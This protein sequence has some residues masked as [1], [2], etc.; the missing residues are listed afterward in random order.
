MRETITGMELLPEGKYI[1][2]VVGIPEKV[3]Q[4]DSFK[5][6]WVLTW[7]NTEGVQKK[8]TFWLFAGDYYPI[9]LACGGV[10]NGKDVDWDD[11]EVDGKC[12]SC[13]LK[14]V[15]TES[16]GKV[17]DNYKFENCEGEIPF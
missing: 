9:V 14:V 8:K 16:K 11:E 1:F 15:K 3:P 2:E 4:G 6:K 5:R 17:Y 13:D 12:F 10:K 7:K